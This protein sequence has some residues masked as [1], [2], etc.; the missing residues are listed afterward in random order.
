MVGMNKIKSL[1][2]MIVCGGRDYSLSEYDY[3]ILTGIDAVWPVTEL[4][5][6]GCAG[7]DTGA[8]RWARNKQIP[9]KRFLPDWAKLGKS[10]G[11]LRNK[12]MA[13][14]ADSCVVFDGGRGTADM[15]LKA[16]EH[17]LVVFDFR[18]PDY[19]FS[20]VL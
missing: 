4:V 8:E 20:E 9:I 1:H 19:E 15:A 3:G 5:S 10:A 11:P 7:A 16:T 17:E 18:G 2:R 14:Y 6:G 13:E 12:E